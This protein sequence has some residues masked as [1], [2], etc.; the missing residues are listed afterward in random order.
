MF[1]RKCGNSLSVSS[2]FCSNCGAKNTQANSCA[3]ETLPNMSSISQEKTKSDKKSR[4]SSQNTYNS[5]Y[6]TK[7]ETVSINCPKC[8]GEIQ[9][10]DGLD[11]FFC[12]YCGNKVVL[13]GMSD[14]S[15]EA[16]V[17]SKK[18]DQEE[19]MQADALF[20]KREM[21][22]MKKDAEREEE[23]QAM[24][25]MYF[26]LVFLVLIIVASIIYFSYPSLKQKRI[27]KKL[28]NLDEEID[29]L[30]DDKDYAEAEKLNKQLKKKIGDLSD[31]DVWCVWMDTYLENYYDITC[32]VRKKKKQEPKEIKL[33]TDLEEV[34]DM[35]KEDVV[36]YL[37]K[38]G[39]VN[40]SCVV[41]EDNSFFGHKKGS[42]DGI[43]IDGY[44]DWEAGEVFYDDVEVI[45]KV[46]EED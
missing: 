10:V 7:V 41:E 16:K 40:I 19:R 32:G 45:V 2:N 18:I 6:K 23:K 35:E 26:F 37:I 20:H 22:K 46:W 43:Y 36:D 1:C 17:R 34:D 21:Y 5:E 42:V 28:G 3:S 38:H 12:M 14:A 29:E 31:S 13:S 15:Y 27:T 4:N 44:D 39:F 25:L 33:Y 11:M 8:G 9:T 30:I 24:K